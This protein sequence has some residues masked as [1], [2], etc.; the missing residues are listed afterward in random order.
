[1]GTNSCLQTY[2]RSGINYSLKKYLKV[3]F[4]MP[5]TDAHGT[6]VTVFRRTQMKDPVP[7]IKAKNNVDQLYSRSSYD[8]VSPSNVSGFGAEGV[9]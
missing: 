8:N 3:G 4:T 7:E 2:Y 1:M 6:A 5:A 9:G